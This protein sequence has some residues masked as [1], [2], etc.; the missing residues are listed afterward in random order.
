MAEHVVAVAAIVADGRALLAHRHPDREWYPDCWDLVG[1]HIDPGERPV[2]ALRRECREELGI[3]VQDPIAVPMPSSDPAV[4]VHGFVVS[5]WSG[6]PT[7]LAPDEHDDLRWF[8]P[9]ELDSL[10][11][12]DPAILPVLTRV[13]RAQV[14]T[15]PSRIP[16]DGG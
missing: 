6:T 16:L 4:E 3:E 13:L 1:G 8:G 7:N 14:G 11:L 9:D 2:D 5:S 15:D 10:R 12:A